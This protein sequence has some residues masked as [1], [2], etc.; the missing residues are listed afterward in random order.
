MGTGANAQ[1]P[2]YPSAHGLCDDCHAAETRWLDFRGRIHLG[3]R[4]HSIGAP[5]PTSTSTAAIVRREVD[6]IRAR[7]AREHHN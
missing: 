7:C 5:V 3:I 4:L 6:A 1:L 2:I